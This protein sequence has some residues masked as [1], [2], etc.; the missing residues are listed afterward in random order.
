MH[1]IP[2]I[3]HVAE[4]AQKNLFLLSPKQT[5]SYVSFS[6]SRAN[7]YEGILRLWPTLEKI[8]GCYVLIMFV[9]FYLEVLNEA[10]QRIKLAFYFNKLES[11]KL[12]EGSKHMGTC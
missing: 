1:A 11:K 7:M 2:S 3:W 8:F 9:D 12:Y 6:A 5:R 4:T 10:S